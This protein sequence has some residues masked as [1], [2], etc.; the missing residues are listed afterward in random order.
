MRKR[1]VQKTKRSNAVSLYCHQCGAE[2]QS[3]SADAIGPVKR[4]RSDDR[5]QEIAAEL[6]EMIISGKWAPEMRVPTRRDLCAKFSASPITIQNIIDQFETDGFLRSDGR[7]GTYVVKTPPHLVNVALLF[8][9]EAKSNRFWH[10]LSTVAKKERTDGL[11]IIQYSNI[12]YNG[13][14]DSPDQ[15]R[16]IREVIR[17]RLMG[18]FFTTPP[19]LV[20]RTPIVTEPGIPRC[21]IMAP[22]MHPDFSTVTSGGTSFQEKSLTYLKSKDR[23]RIA[24]IGHPDISM[25]NWQEKI[26]EYG[27]TTGPQWIQGMSISETRPGGNLARLLFDGSREKRPDGLVI[28]DDNM[29]ESVTKGIAESGVKFPQELDIVAHCNFPCLPPSSV[30]VVRLGYDA[31]EVLETGIRFLRAMRFD[32]AAPKR[33]SIKAVFENELR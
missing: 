26:K 28:T 4:G 25:L 17:K 1:Q 30:P 2:I 29:V 19:F 32:G 15:I 5:F 20:E 22:E 6:K 12:K 8:P 7:N 10:A 33:T 24:V 11:K 18:I 31:V 23:K 14:T 3:P 21:A 13:W 9:D 16:L 27:F